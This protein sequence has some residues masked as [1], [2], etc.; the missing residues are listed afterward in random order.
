M[1]GNTPPAKGRRTVR[2]P[3]SGQSHARDQGYASEGNPQ[4]T[5]HL[6]A[7]LD[8]VSEAVFC[9]DLPTMRFVD[10]NQAACEALG[11]TVD[12]LMQM[13][14]AELRPHLAF[15]QQRAE[16]E[17]VAREPSGRLRLR[18]MQRGRDGTDVPVWWEVRAPASG[19]GNSVVVIVRPRSEASCEESP[20]QPAEATDR[21]RLGA[22]CAQDGIWDWDLEKGEIHC[23]ARWYSMLGKEPRNGPV[24]PHDWFGLVHPR[25]RQRLRDA[26]DAALGG[27]ATRL[28]QEFRIRR[29]EGDYR[30]VLVRGIILRSAEGR[31]RRV[32]GSQTDVS[33]CRQLESTIRRRRLWDP[34]TRLADRRLFRRRLSRALE[35]A[36]RH[37][38]YRFAVLFVDVDRFKQ[39][40]DRH[41][42]RTGDRVLRRVADRLV[43]SVRPGD[44]VA[45]RG[46]DEFTVLVDDLCHP[47][48]VRGVVER[49]C[50][51]LRRPLRRNG[52][53]I[54]VSVSVGAVMNGPECRR[55]E[56]L[57]ERADRAMYEAKSRAPGSYVLLESGCADRS[58]SDDRGR[59]RA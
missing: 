8:A 40:N 4:Q 24:A 33:Y 10:V 54:S 43:R 53:P 37:P 59:R 14:P 49:I 58:D 13:G 3:A 21:Y 2:L 7:A 5:Q 31:A 47:D 52:R 56:A 26:I 38:D 1:T 11:Y 6:R 9:V 27:G 15:Q 12:E 55:P 51:S 41:G 23:S 34:V 30:W 25:D 32:V 35:R 36:E 39:I 44:M 48:D 17:A 46:G 50:T 16:L 29:A 42:H 45:R 22:E 19:Q 18:T 28:E 20:S 57:I